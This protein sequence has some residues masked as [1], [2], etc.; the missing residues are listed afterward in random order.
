MGSNKLSNSKSTEKLHSCTHGNSLD[1]LS[2]RVYLPETLR[3]SVYFQNIKADHDVYFAGMI[4]LKMFFM[5]W[6][7]VRVGE[8]MLEEETGREAA[9]WS[10]VCLLWGWSCCGAGGARPQLQCVGGCHLGWARPSR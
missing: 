8:Y 10:T 9:A 4:Q 2:L 5:M 7:W 1:I 3:L 6:Q